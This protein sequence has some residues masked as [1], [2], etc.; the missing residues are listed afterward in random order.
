MYHIGKFIQHIGIRRLLNPF[1]RLTI[2]QLQA[3]QVFQCLQR[4]LDAV[5]VILPTKI[6]LC[7]ASGCGML[8]AP[9]LIGQLREQELLVIA[10]PGELTIFGVPENP[11]EA[12]KI[13]RLLQS[14]VQI[15]GRRCAEMPY[16]A[17]SGRAAL[18]TPTRVSGH[19]TSAMPGN[20]GSPAG[21]HLPVLAG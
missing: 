4:P 2:Y 17:D 7:L 13:V 18:H 1:S 8:I 3:T 19:A 14:L 20:D 12:S 11:R 21:T 6:K 10:P 15:A 5:T 16:Q 9:Q